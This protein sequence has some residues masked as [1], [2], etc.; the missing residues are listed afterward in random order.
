MAA[1]HPRWC[2]DLRRRLRAAIGYN[3]LDGFQPFFDA[4]H[5][6]ERLCGS[7]CA[8]LG[9]H[10]AD[11]LF[12]LKPSPKSRPDHREHD[13]PEDSHDQQGFLVGDDFDCTV[14]HIH[15]PACIDYP[16]IARLGD[17]IQ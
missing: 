1:F 13:D 7:F 10:P 4:L 15:L 17:A 16:R 3:L 14:M 2:F 9:D 12:V 5:L 6:S 8:L 11:L